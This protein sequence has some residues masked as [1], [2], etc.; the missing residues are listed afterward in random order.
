[1]TEFNAEKLN[2]RLEQLNREHLAP[3]EKLVDE[4]LEAMEESKLVLNRVEQ[5]S[6]SS[7]SS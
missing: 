1:M 2:E 4:L 3:V 7:R 5:S 6:P